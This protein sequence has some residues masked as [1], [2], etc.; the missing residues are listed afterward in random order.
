M[1]TTESNGRETLNGH[2]DRQVLDTRLLRRAFGAFATGV[3]VVT[4]GG[5]QP[6]GMTANSFTS[7]SL[8][9][10]LALLCVGREANMHRI[11][12]TCDHFGVSVLAADQEHVARHFADSRRALGPAQF[13]AVNWH[14]GRLTGVPLITGSVAR[15]ECQVWR[16]YDGGDHTIFIARPLSMSRQEAEDALLF[17]DGRFRRL[18]PESTEV[19]A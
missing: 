2:E 7:V 4:V 12:D 11:L 10:P 18:S 1:S 9:P 5:S 8:D 16:R 14:P 17:F 3:T 19:S 15:F 13:E 6:H